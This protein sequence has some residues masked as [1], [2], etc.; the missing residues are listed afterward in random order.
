MLPLWLLLPLVDGV[1]QNVSDYCKQMH[2]RNPQ[3]ANVILALRGESFRNGAGQ[4]TIH[5]CCPSSYARQ[6][7]VFASHKAFIEQLAA[8]GFGTTRLLATTYACSRG[9]NYTDDLKSWYAPWL[10][11]EAG[12]WKVLPHTAKSYSQHKRDAMAGLNM[13]SKHLADLQADRPGLM[14]Q[15][16]VIDELLSRIRPVVEATPPKLLVMLRFDTAIHVK[17]WALFDECLRTGGPLADF[18]S[19]DILDLIPDSYAPCFSAWDDVHDNLGA[20]TMVKDMRRMFQLPPERRDCINNVQLRKL[21]G[22]CLADDS[23]PDRAWYNR[24]HPN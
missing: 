5:T 7:E 11:G 17:N 3:R 15:S 8:R 16:K 24:G 4:A 18:A 20:G 9:Q 23:F 1:S 19:H 10:R 12:D 13:P 22:T 2:A 14:T 21:T 6:R